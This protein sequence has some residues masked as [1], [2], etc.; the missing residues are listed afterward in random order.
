LRNIWS[1]NSAV[2]KGRL[3]NE[4]VNHVTKKKNQCWLKKW[5][6]FDV[7]EREEILRY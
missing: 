2:G 1:I 4:S 3:E 7:K 5:T 6:R